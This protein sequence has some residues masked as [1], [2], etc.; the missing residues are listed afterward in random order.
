MDSTLSMATTQH[1][2]Y[3]VN[4]KKLQK[5]LFTIAK[6]NN[7]FIRQVN[8]LK[9][10]TPNYFYFIVFQFLID[11]LSHL[12]VKNRLGICWTIWFRSCTS[13]VLLSDM[14]ADTYWILKLYED[15]D[16]FQGRLDFFAINEIL[17][18]CGYTTICSGSVLSIFIEAVWENVCRGLDRFLGKSF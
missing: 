16:Y 12:I 2:C 13:K 1:R 6:Q 15:C 7:T 17:N 4:D 10:T 18:M 8:H 11:C 5:V 14:Y 9:A 3:R